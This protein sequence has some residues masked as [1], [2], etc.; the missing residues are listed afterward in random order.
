M[1]TMSNDYGYDPTINSKAA[2]AVIENHM[3]R[4]KVR[5]RRINNM[6]I[7]MALSLLILLTAYAII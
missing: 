4:V 6:Y 5:A 7:L 3:R 1:K 2:V